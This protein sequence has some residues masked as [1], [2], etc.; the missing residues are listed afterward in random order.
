MQ[1]EMGL[2]IQKPKDAQGD[3]VLKQASLGP[4][5][6]VRAVASWR[7]PRTTTTMTW[8]DGTMGA[9]YITVAEDFAS[10]AVIDAFNETYEGLAR[11]E[12][13]YFSFVHVWLV[14]NESNVHGYDWLAN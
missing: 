1:K 14:N 12:C 9:A 8:I 10:E 2:P 4:Y 5:G 3:W 6:S 7:V 13:T 11:V